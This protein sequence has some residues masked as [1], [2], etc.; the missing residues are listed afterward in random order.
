MLNNL[1][2]Q[3]MSDAIIYWVATYAPKLVGL[4]ILLF[5]TWVISGWAKRLSYRVLEKTRLDLTLTRFFSNLIRY[6]VLLMGMA[7]CLE[8][9]DINTIS[10]AAVIGAA[11]LAIGLALQG[12]LSN[13]AAGVM[14]LAF[15]PF[16]A[17]DVINAA[18]VTVKVYEIELFNTKCD[19]FDNRRIIIPNSDLF[20]NK[21]ENITY[22]PTRRIDVS[23]S[24]AYAADLDATRAV[25]LA[26]AQKI[27]AGLEDPAPQVVLTEMGA[28]SINWQVRLWVNTPDFA[29]SKDALIRAIKYDL[30]AAGISIPFPQMDVHLDDLR[31]AQQA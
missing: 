24:S 20:G 19:T 8:I 15:R 7:T 30:D 25:L 5:I 9:F 29:P 14:L 17:G 27:E 11:G 4:F 3:A 23:A 1:N 2:L 18:G 12:T 6:A 26:A 28:S 21:L 13:F 22:H 16:K 31:P 10:F